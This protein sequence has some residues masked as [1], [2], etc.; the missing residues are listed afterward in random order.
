MGLDELGHLAATVPVEES[1][2]VVGFFTT[3][4]FA[5]ADFNEF[6]TYLEIIS[7]ESLSS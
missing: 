7:Y 6:D 2:H 3:F 5:V 4:Y 1:E